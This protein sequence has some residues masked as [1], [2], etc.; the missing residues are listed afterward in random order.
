MKKDYLWITNANVI[1]TNIMY[2]TFQKYVVKFQERI[3]I[4]LKLITLTNIAFILTA[5]LFIII[6]IGYVIH[7]PD[8]EVTTSTFAKRSI[9]DMCK[10]NVFSSVEVIVWN[11]RRRID[12]QCRVFASEYILQFPA[13]N[14]ISN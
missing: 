8:R 6:I 13:V 4:L 12:R 7:L 5:S 3:L 11:P 1:K 9:S 10:L 14:L 2:R